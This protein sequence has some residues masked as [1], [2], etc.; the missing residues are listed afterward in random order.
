MIR[1]TH[2]AP[3]HV[4]LLYAQGLH[5]NNRRHAK[6]PFIIGS[7]FAGIV[8]Q[9]HP[10]SRFQIGQAV[11]GS[12]PGAFAEYLVINAFKGAAGIRHVPMAWTAREACAVGAS[13]VISLGAF[14][15]AGGVKPNSWVLVTG[16]SGGLGVQALQIAK[17][18][19]AKVI[20]LAGSAEK[21]EMLVKLGAH[22][23]LRYDLGDWETDVKIITNGEG[24]D[25]IYDAVGLVKS[26][27]RC[28]KYGAKVVIVGFAGRYGEMEHVGMNRILLK[29][30]S[31]IG[32]VSPDHS[33][34]VHKFAHT[35]TRGLENMGI[36]I[37]KQSEYYGVSSTRWCKKVRSRQ[38]YT[39]KPTMASRLSLK[40]C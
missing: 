10:S 11:C 13:G 20:C 39:Q 2:V 31:V 25:L 3:T 27:L 33:C 29:G 21:A 38:S 24:V 8:V 26:S 17:A 32:Y 30:A 5:Q 18:K 15:S 16:A 37:R 7:D 22:A 4:D 19:G 12:S 36:E 1:V 40:P 14:K 6:P 28:C 35:L 34:F 9:S 23:C